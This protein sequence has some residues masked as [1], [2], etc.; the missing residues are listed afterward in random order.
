MTLRS[1][2]ARVVAVSS[3]CVG[4]AACHAHGPLVVR[5]EAFGTQE[6]GKTL[7][8][9]STTLA[10]EEAV[11]RSFYADQQYLHVQV[12]RLYA[13]CLTSLFGGPKKVAIFFTIHED[14][15]LVARQLIEVT[16]VKDDIPLQ[17]IDVVPTHRFRGRDFAFGF[18]VYGIDTDIA[19]VQN[20]IDNARK[21]TSNLKGA[22]GIGTILGSAIV[23]TL[24]DWVFARA[25]QTPLMK[26]DRI[27]FVSFE[28]VQSG[29]QVQ[30]QRYLVHGRYV[31]FG[32]P[33]KED[34]EASSCMRDEMN[35][36]GVTR[37]DLSYG[38][39]QSNVKWS[40]GPMLQ[41]RAGLETYRL[42]PYMMIN[43]I[44]ETRRVGASGGAWNEKFAYAQ[45]ALADAAGAVDDKDAAESL[46]KVKDIAKQ[47]RALALQLPPSADPIL[48]KLQE[49]G[50]VPR[51][52]GLSAL[53]T[54]P[55]LAAQAMSQISRVK[56]EEVASPQNASAVDGFYTHAEL[57]YLQDLSN[58]LIRAI[59]TIRSIRR[60][61][62]T[63]GPAAIAAGWTATEKTASQ[64][65]SFMGKT[66]GKEN[67]NRTL[68]ECLALEA[69]VVTSY[70]LWLAG[71]DLN[72]A[73]SVPLT[74]G[75]ICQAF[76]AQ[77]KVCPQDHANKIG[78]GSRALAEATTAC[79]P[80]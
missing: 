25:K 43:V 69:I 10:R 60:S 28:R 12:D 77:G 41:G 22:G 62:R 64:V 49:K 36:Q 44:P 17:G 45:R 66:A 32:I 15:E 35:K 79:K 68:A 18:E 3:I 11:G 50:I 6:K 53:L 73:A 74:K 31:V 4:M 9:H 1:T 40:D 7:E 13:S 63:G 37:D 54:N 70:R 76:V 39:F 75:N 34:L 24:S 78:E 19:L 20:V 23:D 8:L 61:M 55:D 47:I 72:V 27:G 48:P 51:Q 80:K 33:A 67:V 58:T 56:P 46:E 2:I 5:S 52:G 26:F 42:T 57:T 21:M 59:D 14:N 16:E 30:P 29:E 38:W 71:M 65:Q